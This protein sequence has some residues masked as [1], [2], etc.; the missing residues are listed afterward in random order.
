MNAQQEEFRVRLKEV[1]RI[2]EDS[3][4]VL[5]PYCVVRTC[6]EQARL[7]RKSR[8]TEEI[9]RKIQSLRD[10]GMPFLADI[11]DGVGPQAGTLGRHVTNAGPGESW[12]QYGLAADCVPLDNGKAMWDDDR[13]QW[14]TYGAAVRTAGL[15]WAGDWTTSREFPHC[16]LPVGNNPIAELKRPEIIQRAIREAAAI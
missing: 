14:V 15:R 5:L 7:Y 12:H 3:G 9:R 1:I 16:Q 6:E 10:R 4:I 13:P 8:T 11:L 2:C